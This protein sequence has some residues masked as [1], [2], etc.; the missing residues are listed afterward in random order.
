MGKLII[1]GLGLCCG[2][3]TPQGVLD[4]LEYADEV[5]LEYYTSRLVNMEDSAISEMLGREVKILG[6][7]EVEGGDTVLEAASR[8]TALFLTAGDPLVATTH[9]ELRLEAVRRGLEVEIIPAPSIYTVVPSLLGLAHYKFGRTTTLQR[10]VGEYFP[11]SPF[12]VVVENL[13]RGLHT[14][15]LLDIDVESGYY[16]TAGE[17]V[18]IML[19]S[20]RRLGTGSFSEETLVCAIARA[21]SASARLVCRRAGELKEMDLGEPLHTL[22]VP[23]KLHF[24][25]AEALV[26]FAGAPADILQD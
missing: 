8:G 20:E 5:F 6:R 19:E 16:M 10:P 14:L 11:T 24:K 13:T 1:G 9:Q 15:V 17:G 25:E 22:V 18:E 26:E 23:G 2:R 3:D 7:S 12:Q 4:A 21:G